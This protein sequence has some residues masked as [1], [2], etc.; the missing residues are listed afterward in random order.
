MYWPDAHADRQLTHTRLLVVVHSLVMYVPSV[1]MA[2]FWAMQD[3]QALQT[4]VSP[5][6]WTFWAAVR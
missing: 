1:L 5:S 2:R 3:A 4:L 6:L